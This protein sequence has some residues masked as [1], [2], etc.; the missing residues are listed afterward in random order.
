MG[1]AFRVLFGAFAGVAWVMDLA[2]L[3]S[4]FVD[5][6]SLCSGLNDTAGKL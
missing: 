4:T 1:P 5:P 2:P 6:S 3:L